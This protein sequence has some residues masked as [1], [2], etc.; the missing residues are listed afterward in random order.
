MSMD[1]ASFK[2][3]VVER[4]YRYW[5][6]KCGPRRLPSRADLRPEEVP[7][8]PPYMFLV[9]VHGAPLSFRYRLVGTAIT[10][11]AA[12]EYT[13][14]WLNEAEFKGDWRSVF[15]D[16]SRVIYTRTPMITTR[17]APWA[18]REF[19][20]YER[21]VAPLSNSEDHVDMLFGVLH[22]I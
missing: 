20:F 13:G 2:T 3:S 12:R 19:L 14:A 8:L 22:P 11:L 21:L 4:G 1:Q 15:E 16:Y 7:L 6:S 9:D 18:D 5:S 17:R 10:R